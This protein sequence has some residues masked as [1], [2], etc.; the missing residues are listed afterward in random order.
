MKRI[1]IF[2]SGEGSN[3]EAIVKYFADI[4][5][6]KV[7]MVL[8]NK[9]LAGVHDRMEALSIPSTSF[10]KEQWNEAS[11]ILDLLKL[12]SIDLVVL[13]GF[14]AIIPPILIN[15]YS[16]RIINIHPSLLP[17]HGGM[18]MWGMNV[19]K[20]VIDSGDKESGITIHYVTE[21]IDGGAIIE[22][23]KCDVEDGETPETLANKVHQ[24]EYFYYP[25]AI[26]R[27]LFQ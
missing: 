24:L 4:E 2:A 9:V 11:Q 5:N 17:R 12:K 16:G 10:T 23:H 20:S 6:V 25:R 8:S 26:E 22:Q 15:E 3:A 27:L 14:I 18:G 13:A 21:Q 19:H 1:A 7:E